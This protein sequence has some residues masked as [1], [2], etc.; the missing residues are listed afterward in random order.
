MGEFILEGLGEGEELVVR[1]GPSTGSF[2][3]SSQHP[4]WDSSLIHG[5]HG[6]VGHAVTRGLTADELD[7]LKHGSN[8]YSDI[9]GDVETATD[10]VDI[11]GK[12]LLVGLA[13]IAVATG[14]SI[15]VYKLYP[16]FAARFKGRRKAPQGLATS[17]SVDAEIFENTGTDVTRVPQ[18]SQSEWDAQLV[19]ALAHQ[20][21]GRAHLALSAEQLGQLANSRIVEVANAQEIVA[22]VQALDTNRLRALLAELGV[23]P[24][25]IDDSTRTEAPPI[26]PSEIPIALE[27]I[28]GFTEPQKTYQVPSSEMP[29]AG[30]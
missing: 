14:V 18:L 29:G 2:T 23:S 25:A 12:T 13:V 21:A 9:D 7:Q 11:D 6:V 28:P 22:R 16:K 1:K 10:S 3:P 24:S 17:E 4:G 20:L 30:S 8:D 15:A 19:E 27:V 5:E 26:E